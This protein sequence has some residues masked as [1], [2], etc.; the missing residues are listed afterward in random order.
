M[1]ETLVIYFTG[2]DSYYPDKVMHSAPPPCLMKS[3]NEASK[4]QQQ[5]L[6]PEEKQSLQEFAYVYRSVYQHAVR[7]KTKEETS[8]LP[9]NSLVACKP[10]RY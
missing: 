4:E 5:V 1:M 7:A 2:P 9:T 3:V 6:T 10:R 8:H